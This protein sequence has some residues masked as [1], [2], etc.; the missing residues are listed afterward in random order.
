MTFK[1]PTRAG[2]LLVAMAFVFIATTFGLLQLS[3]AGLHSRSPLIRASSEYALGKSNGHSFRETL[4][5]ARYTQSLYT[6]TDELTRRSKVIRREHDIELWSTPNGEVWAP[7]GDH[8]GVL[9]VMHEENQDIYDQGPV[10]VQSGDVVLDVG[11]HIG[12]FSVV[13]LKRGALLVVAIEPAPSTIECLRR[14]LAAEIAQGRVIVVPKGVME[15]AGTMDMHVFHDWNSGMNSFSI[16]WEKGLPVMHL[17]VTTIDAVV[18]D[19]KLTKVDFIKMDI[20]GA[21]RHA[22]SGAQ[23]TIAK[24]RPRMNIASYHLADDATVIPKTVLAA[25]PAYRVSFGQPK[26]WITQEVRPESIE[27]SAPR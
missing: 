25:F 1:S 16:E 14:N 20:E 3:R 12:L 9:G 18:D 23:L 15:R 19:L 17:P 6:G 24:F 13:A 7:A 27:F 8:D 22:L 21:E 11:A 10:T 26:E 2:V 5:A 4:S